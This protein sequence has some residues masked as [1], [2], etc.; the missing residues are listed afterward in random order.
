M[1]LGS[2]RTHRQLRCNFVV[3][4]PSRHE[5]H[6]LSL[7]IREYAESFVPRGSPREL[8]D[9]PA[10]DRGGQKAMTG[11]HEPDGGAKVVWLNIFQ[12]ESACPDP[13]GFEYVLVDLEGCKH[14]NPHVFEVTIGSRLSELPRVRP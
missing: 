10:R 12:Q 6:N 1:S 8:L 9:N 5:P 13:Q 7:S 2:E 14:E 11:C 3:R 4:E